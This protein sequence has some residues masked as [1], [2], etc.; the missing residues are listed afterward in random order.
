MKA[1]PPSQIPYVLLA[2]WNNTLIVFS[3]ACLTTIEQ[4]RNAQSLNTFGLG[5]IF[6]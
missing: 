3:L 1:L 5:P 4:L 2:N 6:F